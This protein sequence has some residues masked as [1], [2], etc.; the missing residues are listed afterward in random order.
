MSLEA[1]A[2]ELE[3]LEMQMQG[4]ASKNK[5]HV[6]KVCFFCFY[7]QR[8]GDP[9]ATGCDGRDARY[10][11]RFPW[12]SPDGGSVLFFSWLGEASDF[13][14]SYAVF[15]EGCILSV[16]PPVMIQLD[17]TTTTVV[18]VATTVSNMIRYHSTSS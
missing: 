5:V 3:R 15:V 2:K 4:R 1:A 17:K 11:R 13:P 14:G 9:Q 6:R 7:H 8:P 10:S 16:L 12:T 18:V